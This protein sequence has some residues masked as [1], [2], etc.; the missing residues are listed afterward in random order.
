[1]QIGL[2]V[3]HRYSCLGLIKLEFSGQIFE[4]KSSN[5]KLQEKPSSGSRIFY[6]DRRT[7]DGQ[8]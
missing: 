2:H 5:I 1:M 6:T 8:K 7:D 3:K 4:K